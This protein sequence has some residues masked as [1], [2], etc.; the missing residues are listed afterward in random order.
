MQFLC[1]F[2]LI[3]VLGRRG[4]G[5]SKGLVNNVFMQ[6]SPWATQNHL[7]ERSLDFAQ[8]RASYT[9]LLGGGGVIRVAYP[10]A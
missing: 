3:W 10:K 5:G 4:E 6:F 1:V 7:E 9:P 8:A 2:H